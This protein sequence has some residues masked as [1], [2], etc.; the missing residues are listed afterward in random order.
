MRRFLVIGIG[1]RIMRDDGVGVQVAEA[2]ATSFHRHNIA[3]HI[4]ETDVQCC[5][6]AIRPGDILI[7]LDAMVLG[8]EPGGLE[9]MSLEDAL[10][11]RRGLRTQHECSLLDLITLH[12]PETQGYLIGIEAAE[13]GF[14][15]VLSAALQAQFE[16]ICTAVL[17]AVLSIKEEAEHA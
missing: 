8:R 11:H 3:L 17:H 1:S 6:D 15:L 12:A 14:G 5:L 7:I 9:V 2:L 10:E 13:I 16:S 4:G